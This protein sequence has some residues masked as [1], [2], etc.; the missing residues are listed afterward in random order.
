[1]DKIKYRLRRIAIMAGM[2]VVLFIIS[3]GAYFFLKMAWAYF[4]I[5]AYNAYKAGHTWGPEFLEP[6]FKG[7]FFLFWAFVISTYVSCL[8][9]SH[10]A[11]VYKQRRAW[12]ET[13]KPFR[14]KIK[15]SVLDKCEDSPRTKPNIKK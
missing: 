2:S 3:V 8:R 9:A 4:F 7:C 12:E 10:Y 14:W 1:M 6:M 5:D 13:Q 15:N 11:E